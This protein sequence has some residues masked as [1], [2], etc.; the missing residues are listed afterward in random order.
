MVM[1]SVLLTIV[2]FSGCGFTPPAEESRDALIA[3]SEEARVDA[4]SSISIG[5][6]GLDSVT[7]LWRWDDLPLRAGFGIARDAGTFIEPTA[8]TLSPSACHGRRLRL[9][10]DVQTSV[11]D[12]YSLW[13]LC[14]RTPT[15]S[16]STD[17]LAN[18]RPVSVAL[19]VF[20]EPSRTLRET[21]T[22]P[23]PAS[24][25]PWT[26]NVLVILSPTTR[27]FFFFENRYPSDARLGVVSE[28][29]ETGDPIT[30]GQLQMWRVD[31]EGQQE[32]SVPGVGI[33]CHASSSADEA[34]RQMFFIPHL[35]CLGGFESC[36]LA[37]YDCRDMLSLP[38]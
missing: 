6:R 21:M 17:A 13:H 31:T 10:P 36:R 12:G 28:S 24:A 19:S 8:R 32:A 4:S 18:M 1:V 7:E 34:H 14:Y 11:R 15:R 23:A 33:V 26:M 38:F 25:N 37:T 22:V 30:H 20:H 27:P 9:S 5:S 29:R 35:A 3:D 2:L 16:S